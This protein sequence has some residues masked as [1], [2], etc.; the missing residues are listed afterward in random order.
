MS[1][2]SFKQE[3]T[4]QMFAQLFA[5]VVK[6]ERQLG[7]AAR[8][9]EIEA[10]EP[11]EDVM[12]ASFNPQYRY[13]T[14]KVAATDSENG[15]FS[16]PIM[17][18]T[19][20]ASKFSASNTFTS[21]VTVDVPANLSMPAVDDLVGA[22]FQGPY[23][24]GKS[25]YC[26]YGAAGGL[27]RVFINSV[28]GDYLTVTEY[29]TGSNSTFVGTLFNV[30]KPW[31]LQ[32]TPWDGVSIQVHSVTLIYSY[33]NAQARH[34]RVESGSASEGDMEIQL[35]IPAYIPGRDQI[36]VSALSNGSAISVNSI[37]LSLIDL[38]DDGRKWARLQ[39]STS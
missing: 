1:L 6:L 13:Y 12:S 33:I 2:G 29:A 34:T 35:V 22:F 36:L 15:C 30:L 9:N 11:N 25:R 18:P 39:L 8:A 10:A 7:V 31:K 5:R 27:K 21:P 3:E 28:F 37:S 17:V 20:T 23:A 14:I 19:D 4:A 24:V 38:N 32:Q 16:G 26:L